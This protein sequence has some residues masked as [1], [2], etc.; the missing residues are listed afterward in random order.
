MQILKAVKV[1]Y[2]WFDV[3]MSTCNQKWWNLRFESHILHHSAIFKKK[4][5]NLINVILVN[6]FDY[7]A[8]N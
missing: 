6:P 8:I 1:F 3:N 4:L 7:C 2:E 5:P